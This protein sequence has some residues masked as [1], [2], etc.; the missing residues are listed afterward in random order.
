M[1][2]VLDVVRF[3]LMLAGAIF[4]GACA[5]MEVEK[6]GVS[7]PVAWK[8]CLTVATVLLIWVVK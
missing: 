5:G 1:S 4:L 2:T 3:L 7:G 6:L 8:L